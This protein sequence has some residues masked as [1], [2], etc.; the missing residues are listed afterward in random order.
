[1]QSLF[2]IIKS[3]VTNGSELISLPDIKLMQEK[4]MQKDN[5]LPPDKNAEMY[6]EILHRAKID[7]ETSAE[8]IIKNA[9][10]T[11]KNILVDANNTVD[12]IK[13]EAKENGYQ[14]GYK[15]GY[16]EGYEFGINEASS[17]AEDI[18]KNADV[19]L[20]SVKSETETY[21]KNKY[22]EIMELSITIAK[23]IIKSEIIVNPEIL[24]KISENVLSQA[25]DRTHVILKVNPL[26]FNI[27]KNKKD[28]LSIYVENP[29]NLFIIAD[30][31]VTQG[32]VK[33]E[34]ASGFIDGD[35][36]TQLDMI[37]KILLRN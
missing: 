19:Y 24:N 32:S 30:S 7:A 8:I 12:N 2:K 33:A 21:I 25:T 35:I 36:D 22:R 27:V 15:Q 5:D 31:G 20:E 28:D 13:N 14:Q 10:N 34:T 17:L 4:K 11:A 6:D 29:N 16:T 3:P 9:Q 18:R 37:A 23:Q 26:D 1:M